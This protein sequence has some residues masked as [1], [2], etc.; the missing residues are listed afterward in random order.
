MIR[1]GQLTIPSTHIKKYTKSDRSANP[2][3]QREPKVWNQC[4]GRQI[5]KSSL[6][7]NRLGHSLIIPAASPCLSAH[8]GLWGAN[9][10]LNPSPTCPWRSPAKNEQLQTPPKNFLFWRLFFINF[11]KLPRKRFSYRESWPKQQED[12]KN[13]P[14]P[15]TFSFITKLM[16]S[17]CKGHRHCS[18][19]CTLGFPLPRNPTDKQHHQGLALWQKAPTMARAK[20]LRT[21]LQLN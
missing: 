17:I 15:P 13:A 14:S 4:C 5:Q 21:T 11:Y 19:C 10:L 7:T 8:P 1:P 6:I 9:I 3:V 20:S 12:M 18:P 16:R 2:F